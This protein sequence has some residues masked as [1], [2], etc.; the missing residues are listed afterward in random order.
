MKARGPLLLKHRGRAVAYEDLEWLAQEASIQ[1]ARVRCL[2]A[3]D[4]DTA[5]KI[6]LLIVPRSDDTKPLPSPGLVR[7]VKDYLDARRTPTADLAIVGPAYVDVAV[8][9][10]V[11][12]TSFEEADLVRR[13]IVA[14]LDAFL[15]ALT[16]APAGG[17]WE[18]GRDV[19]LSEV[20]TVIEGGEGVDHV[21]RLSLSGQAEGADRTRDGGRRVELLDT[22]GSCRRRALT[23][24]PWRR[25]EMPLPIPDLDDRSF[26]DLLVE[27]RSLIPRL[28]P[29]WTNHN[30]ADPGITLIELF[31]YLSELLIYR[32]NRVT[33]DNVRSF[34]KLLNGPTWRPSGPGPQGLAQDVRATILTLRRRERAV[35]TD[36][37]EALAVEADGRVLRARA[38]ARRN[39]LM[40]LDREHPAS[41]SIVIVPRPEGV[42]LAR[43]DRIPLTGTVHTAGVPS[44]ALIGVGTTFTTEADIGDTLELGALGTR[45]VVAVTADALLTLDAPVGL[46]GPPGATA[47][48]LDS[49]PLAGTVHTGGATTAELRGVGTVFGRELQVGDTVTIT[50]AGVRRVTAVASDT[51]LTLD[52]PV[53]L[54]GPAAAPDVLQSVRAYLEPRRLLTAQVNVTGPQYVNVGI[55]AEVVAAP[56]A[57]EID[58][59]TQVV[60]AAMRFLHPLSGGAAGRGWPFG[61]DVFVSE[62]YEVLEGLAAVDHVTTLTLVVEDAWREIRNDGAS[63]SGSRSGA[64][65]SRVRRSPRTTSGSRWHSHVGDGRDAELVPASPAR[66]ILGGSVPRPV[67][68]RLR[69]DPHGPGGSRGPPARGL[70]QTIATLADLF[71][72]ARTPDEFLSWLAGWAALSL[73]ADWSAVQQREFLS[74]VVPLYRRRGTLENLRELL[75]IY[76]GPTPSSRNA[77]SREVQIG[78]RSTIGRDAVI[79]G[80]SAPPFPRRPWPSPRRIPDRRAGSAGQSIAALTDRVRSQRTRL[81]LR[82]T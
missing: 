3:R 22:P 69:A 70:E 32:L 64:T 36:D 63:W 19:F 51:T 73:E 23:R 75:R 14:N 27:G 44:T 1:V 61:R 65:R 35:T 41:I 8:S 28:A 6:T 78:V 16:G 25:A 57:R 13:R 38:V 80:R 12:P 10:D 2:G 45:T 15:H 20:V 60:D 48:R 24:S 52:A 17:G 49:R 39:L 7:L 59:K 50:G 42:T 37:Y 82:I 26:E 47:A 58:V 5:G 9:A 62:L 56:R 29:E 54:P 4:A 55:R 79:G 66:R 46:G 76:P 33:D 53:T 67:P 81:D 30:A 18:F 72:P 11:V 34:L 68:A 71:D 40:D 31:A 77:A 21:L 43:V 74:R